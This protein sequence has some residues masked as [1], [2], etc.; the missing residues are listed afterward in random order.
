MKVYKEYTLKNGK[1][2]I[3]RSSEIEDAQSELDFYKQEVTET[4]FLS[5]G[6]DDSFPTVDD[7]IEGNKYYLADERVCTVVA[8]YEDKLV[9]SGHIDY[10]SSKKRFSHTCDID[11]GVLKDYWGLGIGGRIMKTL[12]EVASNSK[13]ERITLN[14]AKDNIRAIDMYKSFGFEQ[15]GIWPKEMKYSD[16]TYAD[17][18][19]MVKFL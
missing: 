4:Q 18:I 19:S 10:D 12:L 7:F 11:L 3:I 9:G 16:G 8:I 5:R 13:F 1:N 2:L 14:V 15:I 17:Y 6:A